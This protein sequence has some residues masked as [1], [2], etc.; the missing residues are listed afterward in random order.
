MDDELLREALSTIRGL[1]EIIEKFRGNSW[2]DEFDSTSYQADKIKLRIAARLVSGGWIKASER[3]PESGM[4][5]EI[6]D[7]EKQGF[8]SLFRG[9]LWNFDRD[10]GG[11]TPIKWRHSPALP[12]G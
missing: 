7:G 5:V 10:Y 6:S 11:G 4:E 12:K 9:H 1:E 3:L 2:N 8:G